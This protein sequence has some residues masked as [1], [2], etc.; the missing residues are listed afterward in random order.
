MDELEARREIARLDY[1]AQTAEAAE[2]V[3]HQILLVDRGLQ[4]ML[5]INGGALVALFTLIGSNAH[6]RLVPL[7]VWSSFGAFAAGILLS[8]LANLGAFISQGQYHATAQFTAWEAQRVMQ[9]LPSG[10]A[11]Q[12]ASAYRF[13][14][15][16]EIAGIVAALL[17]LVAFVAGCGLALAGVLPK[18]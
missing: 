14:R 17:A 16:A 12:A 11:D 18:G 3:K 1:A 5:L 15:Q 4:G 7:F 8:L 2:R 9:D 6:L 13:G 10:Y